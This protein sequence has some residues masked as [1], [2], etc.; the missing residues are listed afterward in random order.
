[1][2]AL[3]SDDVVEDNQPIGVFRGRQ[4]VRAFV[5]GTFA[6]LPDLEVV[7]DE[8]LADERTAAVRWRMGGTFSG[9]PL[10]GIEPTG[11]RVDLRGVDWLDVQDGR[12]VRITAYW[13]GLSFSRAVGMM[14]PR[15]SPREKA[16]LAA[17]N[18]ATKLR[19]RLDR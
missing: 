2:L 14:P 11:G 1:M 15:G 18:F 9:A 17:F 3:C 8:I 4:E 10:N 19:A 7:A 5:E 13:D 16:M 12:I 6:G